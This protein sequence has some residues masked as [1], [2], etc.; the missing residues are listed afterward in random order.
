MWPHWEEGQRG[1]GML[2]FS[3]FRSPEER[4]KFKSQG[5]K[6]CASNSP[7]QRVIPPITDP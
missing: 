7:G 6:A 3:D 4:L 5:S 2:P 1:P